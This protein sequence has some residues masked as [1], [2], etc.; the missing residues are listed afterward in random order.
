MRLTLKEVADLVKGELVGDPNVAIT[1]ISGI[2]EAKEGEI[3]FLANPKYAYLLETTK[4]AAIITSHDQFK[5]SKPL[6]KTDNPS[7]AFY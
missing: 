3:T 6:I 1:G 4:A 2:K 5:T 7:I